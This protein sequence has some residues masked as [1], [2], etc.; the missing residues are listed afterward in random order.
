MSVRESATPKRMIARGFR[1]HISIEWIYLHIR[2]GIR[3]HILQRIRL[4]LRVRIHGFLWS[5]FYDRI[6]PP[7]VVSKVVTTGGSDEKPDDQR[8]RDDE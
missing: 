6:F 3:L 7:L 1:A 4:Y 2:I 8:T 5:G